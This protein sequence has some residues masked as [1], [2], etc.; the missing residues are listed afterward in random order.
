MVEGI[1][2]QQMTAGDPAGGME[3]SFLRPDHIVDSFGLKPGDMAADF[4]CGAG[5][6]VIPLARAVGSGGRVFAID[7]QKEAL[8]ALRTRAAT[9]HLLN[10]DY[11]WADLELPAGSHLK[12]Q[13]VALV[14]IANILFQA[15]DKEQVIREGGRVLRPGGKL[16]ILEWDDRMSGPP[17]NMRVTK[18]H[19]TELAER[20][21][22]S[23]VEE[24]D[25]GAHHYGLLFNKHS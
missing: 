13:S 23:L 8:S 6:F 11:V 10:I 22:F 2:T 25:G 4:G 12:D 9:A 19:A 3:E 18:A 24:F 7:I 5:F 21:G 1:A 15:S 14:L 17:M 16:A 20:C